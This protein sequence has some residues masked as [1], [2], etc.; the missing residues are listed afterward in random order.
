MKLIRL[1]PK[2]SLALSLLLVVI[3]AAQP[4]PA[5][6]PVVIGEGGN[7]Y[8]LSPDGTAEKLTN[9]LT[10]GRGTLE[11]YSGDDLYPSP[12][13]VHL[14]WRDT[15]RFFEAAFNN[16]ELGNIGDA[17]VD[18]YLL[19]RETREITAIVK[20][21]DLMTM[22]SQ[23]TLFYRYQTAM[24]WSPDG[25]QFAFIEVE[26]TLGAAE[27][28]AVRLQ[29]FDLA[30]GAVR[31]LV[32][33]PESGWLYWLT[34]GIV[35]NA[36]HDFTVYSPQ[37]GAVLA[38]TRID[39][40][41]SVLQTHNPVWVDGKS[42]IAIHYT[43]QSVAEEP[44]ITKLFDPLTGEYLAADGVLASVAAGAPETS[45]RLMGGSND[46]TAR[47]INT[48]DGEVLW[49]RPREAPFPNDLALSPDGS[50]FSLYLFTVPRQVVFGDA[51]GV[52][53]FEYPVQGID[54]GAMRFMIVGTDGVGFGTLLDAPPEGRYT[55]FMCG[56]S[57]EPQLTAGG[58]GRVLPGGANR[59][60]AEPHIN[61]ERIGEI[62]EGAVFNV[63]EGRQGVCRGG[64]RWAHVE[65]NGVI[66]WTAENSGDTIFV[67][68]VD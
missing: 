9:N 55:T 57:R 1:L 20:H 4:A 35:I 63:L 40:L 14:I 47:S 33:Q 60:R 66:G 12:D 52:T 49:T 5:S 11:P 38:Q 34:D 18:L 58:Q 44:D 15:P 42:Y 22:D 17:P 2:L 41:F 10:D 6:T 39:S 48:V 54:W 28:R 13:N 56:T 26:T 67:E 65:Y 46:N 36:T 43:S 30:S 25:S 27:P 45:L 59:L 19:N 32:E 3:T 51:S 21:P 16:G 61:A 23:T 64:I 53:S 7:L 62:P 50:M 31:T 24:S 68:P 8:L 37:D 29:V